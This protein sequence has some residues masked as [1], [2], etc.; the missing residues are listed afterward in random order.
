MKQPKI[1]I[2]HKTGKQIEDEIDKILAG[3]DRSVR[4]RML[5]GAAKAL[6]LHKSKEEIRNEFIAEYKKKYGALETAK[7]KEKAL[8]K[9]AEQSNAEILLTTGK[10]PP[11]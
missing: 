6:L 4:G 11:A 3:K 9:L 10:Q 7:N 8:Q 2:P 1:I 5:F